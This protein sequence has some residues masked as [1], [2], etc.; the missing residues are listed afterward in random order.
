MKKFLKRLMFI[1]I[2][3]FLIVILKNK[4]RY[5]SFN[6]GKFLNVFKSDDYASRYIYVLDREDKSVEY[7][8]NSR[9]RAYPASLTKIMT[10]IVALEHIDDL[11]AVAPIDVD[12]YKEMVANNASMAGF[13][14][15]EPVTYRDLLYGTILSSGGEAANSLAINVAGSVEDFV[16]L[17]NEKASELGLEDTHFTSPEGLHDKN[18]YTSAYDMAKLLDY[19]LDNGDF[20]AIF[21]KKTFK[22]TSTMDHPNGIVLKSTVLSKLAG[23]SEEG[24][25][26]VGGKSGTTYEAGECWA[27]LGIKEDREYICIVMGAP[28]KDISNPDMAQID[29]TIKLYKRI[30][31]NK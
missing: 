5:A 12:T 13:Y 8:K 15:R 30:K 7:E 27:T 18:Q 2:A 25:E 17:M 22:T 3:L 23:I 1:V 21:T 10:T 6:L 29:D 26:I 9:E 31:T 28:L 4:A 20:R 19:A 16:R 24:F 14:G 11:S